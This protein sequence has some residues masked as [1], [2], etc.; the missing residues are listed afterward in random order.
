MTLTLR[1]V[2]LHDR[3]GTQADDVLLNG[4]QALVRALLLQRERDRRLGLN[5]AGYVTGYRG[6][7]LGGL[8][9]TLWAAAKPLR[10]AQVSFDP[11]N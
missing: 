7:P 8:D 9:Q 5:T 11:D 2:T 10:A 4:N 1:S 6:S 3:Y